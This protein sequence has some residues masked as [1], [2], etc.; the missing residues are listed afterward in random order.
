M[1]FTA[2]EK[3][4]EASREK[5]WEETTVEDKAER[6]RDEVARLCAVVTQLSEMV[7]KLGGHIHGA[8]GKIAVPFVE[9]LGNPNRLGLFAHD[10]GIPHRIRKQYERR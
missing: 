5:Y 3:L 8:D 9:T 7:V 2:G 1:A 4:A 6:L 10:N